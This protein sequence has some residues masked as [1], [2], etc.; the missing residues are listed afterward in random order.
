M[1]LC[2]WIVGICLALDG[3]FSLCCPGLVRSLLGRLSPELAE[4]VDR[5]GLKVIRLLGLAE[6][7]IG[8]GLVVL[9]SRL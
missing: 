5:Y 9:A 4:R 8:V 6:C 1:A 3:S 7:L 2:I